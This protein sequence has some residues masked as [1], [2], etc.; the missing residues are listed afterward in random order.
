MIFE[1]CSLCSSRQIDY[2]NALLSMKVL[3]LQVE[4]CLC[5]KHAPI[6]RHPNQWSKINRD[7]WT[8]ASKEL[9][10]LEED[11]FNGKKFSE[12]TCLLCLGSS[13]LESQGQCWWC[14]GKGAVKPEPLP[15][16]AKLLVGVAI[17]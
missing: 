15:S 2:Q 3:G 13:Q 12:E 4:L 14:Q 16:W 7:L 10:K 11:Y 5:K 9:T 8:E 6:A 1:H 17:N